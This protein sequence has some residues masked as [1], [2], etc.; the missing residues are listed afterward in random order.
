MFCI[1]IVLHTHIVVF[2]NETK[3]ILLVVPKIEISKKLKIYTCGVKHELLTSSCAE[4][5]RMC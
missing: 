5:G 2:I 1:H 4:Y 3:F